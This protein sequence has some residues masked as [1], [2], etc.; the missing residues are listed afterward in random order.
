MGRDKALLELDGAPLVVRMARVA[1]SCAASVT[2]VAPRGRY[3]ALDVNLLADCW[4]GEGPLGGIVTALAASPAEWNV[5]LG[6]DL[7]FLTREWLAWL[8]A[9]AQES[10][11]QA[12]V[13]ESRRGLEPLA[14]IY[15]AACAA[16]LAAEFERGV[17]S[18]T[19]ALGAISY[20]RVAAF[21]WGALDPEGL[22]FRN[23]NTPE[24]FAEAQRRLTKTTIR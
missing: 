11:A 22:L 10:P 6:C 12:V 2:I 24:D 3:A 13:P 5:I 16:P 7:L 15:R 18:I 19:D 8:V 4:P 21:E 14:A 1:E 17:R 20:E 9:R 23:V